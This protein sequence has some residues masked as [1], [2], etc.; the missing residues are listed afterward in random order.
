MVGCLFWRRGSIYAQLEGYRFDLIRRRNLDTGSLHQLLV[1]G[2]FLLWVFCDVY[3][4]ASSPVLNPRLESA[5]L[6]QILAT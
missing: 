4:L 5:S 3:E 6:A 2:L 1:F